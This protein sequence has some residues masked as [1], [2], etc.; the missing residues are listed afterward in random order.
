MFNVGSR[1]GVKNGT[2]GISSGE[3]RAVFTLW[4]GGPEWVV[5]AFELQHGGPP[6]CQNYPVEE[7][8][9]G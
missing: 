1:V 8:Q 7:V 6:I 9:W 4:E 5:V 2:T 3:V